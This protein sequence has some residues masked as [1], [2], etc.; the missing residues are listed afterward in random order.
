MAPLVRRSWAPSGHTPI[1]KQR[2]RSHQKVSVIA[3]IVLSPKRRRLHCYF[4]LYPNQNLTATHI[5]AFLRTLL[6][7]VRTPIVLLWDRLPGHRAAL[8]ARLERQH[9]RLH[10][11]FFPSY[12]PELNPVEYLWAYLKSNPLAQF[13]PA[14][15]ESLARTARLHARR[16]QRKPTLLR[17][18][19]HAS[20]L[21][22][23]LD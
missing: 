7:Q 13:A 17:G 11:E 21:S 19:I 16:L 12:A 8:I 2:A 4:R 3:T 1:L 18:F 20:P 14:D 10:L 5:A 9:R 15:L 23:R 6:A 22:L